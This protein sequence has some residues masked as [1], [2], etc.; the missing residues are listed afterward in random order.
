MA[1]GKGGMASGALN[2]SARIE[3]GSAGER[4]RLGSGIAWLWRRDF[5][6]F[7]MPIGPIERNRCQ[8]DGDAS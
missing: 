8:C 7:I 3:N 5:P 4:G 1:T 6:N 2:S